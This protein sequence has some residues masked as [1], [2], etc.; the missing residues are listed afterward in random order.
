MG[1]VHCTSRIY[2]GEQENTLIRLLASESASVLVMM[3]DDMGRISH[4]S[5]F[6][7]ITTMMIEDE[8]DE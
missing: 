5:F 7:L 8:D 4:E 6:L 1:E 2:D 3:I